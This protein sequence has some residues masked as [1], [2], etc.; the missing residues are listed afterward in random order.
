MIKQNLIFILL[1]INN[2]QYGQNLIINPSFE[3]YLKDKYGNM[4]AKD[5]LV[6]NPSSIDYYSTLSSS[7]N[8]GIPNNLFGFHPSYDGNA[9][10]GFVL[11]NWS[12]EMEHYTAVLKEAL[13][14]DSL[15]QIRFHI[16]Y[17]GD[18]VW[19]YSKSIELLFTKESK[20]L[21]WDTRYQFLFD[22]GKHLESSVKIDIEK[23]FIT[24]DWVERTAEYKASGGE[25]FVTFGL[26]YQNDDFIKLINKY[27][28][29]YLKGFEKQKEFINTHEEYPIFRNQNFKPTIRKREYVYAY[30]FLDAVSIT[31]ERKGE[32]DF[33]Y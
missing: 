31:L 6:P 2:I 4:Y 23:A 1:L 5:W 17:A 16:R 3:D 29:D 20:L 26:F 14:K 8:Y 30:Y 9:Y 27:I 13:K 32:K 18:A 33:T 15:Y 21:W 22:H 24:R 25:K 7:N 19:L 12:G 11:Y 28:K 10:A